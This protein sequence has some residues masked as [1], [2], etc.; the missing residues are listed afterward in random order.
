ML[1]KDELLEH[2]AKAVSRLDGRAQAICHGIL[3]E[4]TLG[5]IAKELGVCYETAKRHWRRLLAQLRR[6][7]VEAGPD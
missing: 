6:E 7:L 3:G 4:K 5:V 2:L 1:S